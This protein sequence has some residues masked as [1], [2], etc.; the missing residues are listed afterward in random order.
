[1]SV[2]F[3]FRTGSLSGTA[4]QAAA[5]LAELGYDCL[6][7]CLEAADVR[8][9]TM[10]EERAKGLARSF[11][12]I[13]IDVASL[14]YH[15]DREPPDQR[16]ANQAAAIRVAAWMGAEILILNGEKS[17]DQ[18]RQWAEHVDRLKRLCALAEQ[19]GVT[20]AVEPE[21]LLVIGSSQDALD[22]V[23]AVGS[24]RLKVNLDVGHAA[25]TDP[26]LAETVQS[27][28]DH[29]V[30]LHLEDIAGRV[31]RHLPFGQGDIDF[32]ALKAALAEV[33]YQGPY[34]VDLFGQ[35]VEPRQVAAD[36]LAA[37]RRLF[38]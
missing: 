14:S 9:E 26:D 21:P 19:A 33:G 20:L 32:A 5:T 38:T 22:L 11:Q 3:G 27:L 16:A 12:E 29:L 7:L 6:E 34:V 17:V 13:G 18:E 28:G 36:A 37:L 25:I 31:H 35:D 30:H 2:P 1:M 24:D 15:A 10:T 8:P 23:E 4:E